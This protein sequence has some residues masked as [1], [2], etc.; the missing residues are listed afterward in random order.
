MLYGI[1]CFIYL[2]LRAEAVMQE[3]KNNPPLRKRTFNRPYRKTPGDEKVL[4]MVRKAAHFMKCSINDLADESG[5]APGY[6]NSNYTDYGF[7][8]IITKPYK[9]DELKDILHLL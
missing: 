9:V 8:G 5:Q 7:I 4:N 3:R 6:I 1:E 2:Y